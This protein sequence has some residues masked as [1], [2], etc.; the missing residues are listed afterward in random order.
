MLGQHD[1]R[2]YVQEGGVELTHGLA[3]GT[4]KREDDKWLINPAFSHTLVSCVKGLSLTNT[5]LACASCLNKLSY[6]LGSPMPNN[7]GPDPIKCMA[8]CR[9]LSGRSKY[10]S[11][12]ITASCIILQY[13]VVAIC[14]KTSAPPP[15]R[16]R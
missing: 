7:G 5:H 15:R 13:L 1:N 8:G 10:L 16:P 4:E 14:Y 12:H 9:A 2:T 6:L 3:S 11:C